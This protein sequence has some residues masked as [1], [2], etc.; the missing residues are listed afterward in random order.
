MEAEECDYSQHHQRRRSCSKRRWTRYSGLVK[1]L[2]WPLVCI[3]ESYHYFTILTV[4]V[5]SILIWTTIKTTMMDYWISHTP[6]NGLQSQTPTFT[7][8]GKHPSS[9]TA[10]TMRPKIPDISTLL[11]TITTGITL[12]AEL[13]A[14]DTA[15]GT[16]T[17]LTLTV[18]TQE[19]T[20]GTA[21][22]SW[23]RATS[24]SIALNQLLLCIVTLLGEPRL[25]DLEYSKE[26]YWFYSRYANAY[27][28]DLGIGTN[29]APV[30]K[31]TP[32]SMPYSYS[33][34]GS[35]NVKAAVVGTAGATLSF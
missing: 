22:R 14:W 31:L 35:A 4:P 18:W 32:S 11:S 12:E 34:L 33:L 17:T 23:S 13:P 15:L 3:L 5:N 19:S 25:Q 27:D 9:A 6:R 10:T 1:C 21:H 29:T 20:L 2:G 8:T 26:G 16:Y 30:G 24:L 7:T 28:N